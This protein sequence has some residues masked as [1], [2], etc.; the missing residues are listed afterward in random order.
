MNQFWGSWQD[1]ANNADD[2]A[3]RQVVIEQAGTLT[4]QLNYMSTRLSSFRTNIADGGVGPNF[5]GALPRTVEDINDIAERIADLNQRILVSEGHNVNANDL[6]DTRDLLVR[7]LSGLVDITVADDGTITIDGQLLVSADGA[8]VNDLMI[9]DAD[10]NPIQLSL[11]GAAVNVNGGQLAGWIEAATYTE[12]MMDQIDTL[13]GTLIS[14]VNAIHMSGY[15]LDGNDGL[16]FF[17]GTT[18]G[19]IAVNSLIHDPSNPA[20]DNPRL[21]A[22]ANT[23]HD[24]GP[25]RIPNVGDGAN[26]LEIA[27]LSYAGLAALND[28]TFTEFYASL[29]GDL[30]TTVANAEAMANDGVDVI[31][32]LKNAIQAESGVNLDEEL[33]EM[34]QAQRA[35]QASA[36]V[37][38]TVDELLQ[39][40]L[41]L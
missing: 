18:A 21:I 41:N 26:A 30:G 8:T 34:M 39:T 35:Y 28:Q 13:A 25:P 37:I 32:M 27:D 22:A 3:F 33:I 40:V 10:S 9:M 23:L 36:R 19:D 16:E 2:L 12:Y 4:D 31:N 20:L 38:T 24:M 1:L 6:K 7:E 29:V 15:D 11:D 14:E 5:S 17:T